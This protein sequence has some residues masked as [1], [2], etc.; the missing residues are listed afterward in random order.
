MIPAVNIPLGSEFL[1]YLIDRAG[2][3]IPLA[4]A[5]YNAGP[6]AVRRWLPASPMETDV[7]AENI[8]FNETRTY[9]QRVAWHA[10]VFGWLKERKPRDVSNWLGTIQAP[11]ADA[12][13]TNTN[14]R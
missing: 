13:T 11:A 4:V 5:G 7:W 2:G 14:S 6:A 8:P 1:K 12:A 10:L 9:V 3:Q